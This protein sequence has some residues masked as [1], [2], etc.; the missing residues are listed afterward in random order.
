MLH[1]CNYCDKAAKGTRDQLVD[2]GWSFVDIRAPVR[3]YF[4]TCP[5][6]FNEMKLDI[7][8]ATG[9]HLKTKKEVD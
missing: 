8:K 4:K 6:H 9:L 3:R 2:I 1:K 7:M 5:E